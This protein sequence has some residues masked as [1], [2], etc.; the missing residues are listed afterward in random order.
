VLN[1]GLAVS[2]GIEKLFPYKPRKLKDA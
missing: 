2:T 1:P